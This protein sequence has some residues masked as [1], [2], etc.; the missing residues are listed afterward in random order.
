MVNRNGMIYEIMLD[1]KSWIAED[2]DEDAR[3]KRDERFVG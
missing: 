1:L 2:D 3:E